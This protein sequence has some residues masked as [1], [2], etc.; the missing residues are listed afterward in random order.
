MPILNAQ[1]EEQIE[2]LKVRL[3]D[4]W[5][6]GSDQAFEALF[7]KD[8]VDQFHI[9]ASVNWWTRNWQREKD[10]QLTIVRFL[11]ISELERL[12]DP[13]SAD[14][15][16][17]KYQEVLHELNRPMVMNGNNYVHNLPVVGILEYNVTTG[18]LNR[19]DHVSVGVGADGI[20]QFSLRRR[21]EQ[22]G[23]GQPTT[24]RESESEGGDKPQPES[25][26]RSR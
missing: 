18:R 23:T 24:R 10:P 14:S 9:D 7:F 17:K 26:G 5:R 13:H 25:E 6:S 20:L 19:H 12:A 22:A 4:A 16:R 21:S 8:G 11:H 1:T 2:N 3:Q 15:N